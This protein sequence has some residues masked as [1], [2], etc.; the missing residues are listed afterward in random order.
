MSQTKA[1][2]KI[3]MK[4]VKRLLNYIGGKNKVL[5]VVVF[6]C[7]ALS[8]AAGVVGSSFIQ[9]VIDDYI[10]PLLLSSNPDFSG[11]LKAISIMAIVYLVGIVSTFFYNRIMS[12]VAQCTLKQIRDDMF[13]H[14]QSLPI[15]YFD[16]HSFGDVMSRYT[17]DTDTLRQMIAVSLPQ[18]ISSLITIVAVLFTMI[19]LNLWLTLLILVC[20][21]GMLLLVRFLGGKSV[22]FFVKQ[23]AILGTTNGFIEEM[24]NGQKVVKVFNYEDRAKK[25]FDQ[26]NDELCRQATA[27]NSFVNILWPIIGSISN[28]QYALLAIVG[29]FLAIKGIGGVTIGVIG[30]FLLLSK[31]FNQPIGQISQQLNA[32]VMALAG[33]GRIF[34][35]IDE[36]S[37]VDNGYVTL[38]KVS[39]VDDKLVETTDSNG[40]FAWKH[41]HH[42]GTTTYTEVKGD[43]VFDNIDFGYNEEK[44]VL[45]NVSLYAKPGQKIA[46]VG[47]TGAGK[48][49]VTNL[50]NRFYD[51]A[52]GKIRFDGINI[53][54]IKKNDLRQS[55]GVILQDTNLFSGTVM[56]NIRYGKLDATD[57]EV[58]F[59]SKLANA[60]DFIRRLPNGYQTVID[61]DG[62]SLSQGQRQLLSIA[63]A[64]VANPPVMIMDEAT[65]SIDTR[66][67][68][69]VQSGM[70]KLMEG[71][72][73]FV[74]AHR[75]STVKNANAIIVLEKGRIIERG[76][77]ES[78]IA[79]KGKYYQL[80]TGSFEE[81]TTSSLEV[82]AE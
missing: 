46:F 58:I 55:L 27:A 54:K 42:D 74:I 73:V 48:T 77:H 53:N 75:L 10:A 9:R 43:V 24:I 40:I 64:A 11:L 61:G 17:N 81:E 72:T 26:K 34:E 15:K 35:L 79:K 56:D 47:A 62:E 67:E 12:V 63:R 36:Q 28:I 82:S 19:I 21:V 1:K 78:L 29:G 60:D 18:T 57:D 30:S 32:V 2:S 25:K 39:K 7:I 76:D 71:R 23:Q 49:T 68:L 44:M 4:T 16:T 70:D 52:D 5:L 3:N 45:H 37:E 6:I 14:M 38:V 22:K 31:N 50:I 51:I 20:S 69:I 41:P 66:T 8:S 80:Y 33:S 13:N 59:A 65:S